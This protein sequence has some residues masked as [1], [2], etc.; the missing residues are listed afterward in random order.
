MLLFLH[1]GDTYRSMKQLR[2]IR[3][4]FLRD[5]DPSGLNLVELDAEKAS[6]EE[7]SAAVRSAPFLSTKRLVVLKGFL[8]A[9]KGKKTLDKSLLELLESVPEEAI[10]VIYEAAGSEELGKLES[11][12][13]L[14]K[15][16]FYPEYQPLS[17]KQLQDWVKQEAK[18]RGFTFS[19]DA[20]K[21]Y[22]AI[23]GDDLWKIASELDKF[24]AHA[25]AS[26]GAELDAAA[27]RDLADAKV[28]A[29]LFEFLDMV[30]AR[31]PER[32][33]AILE[34]LLEQGESEVM[35][36]SRLQ[37]HVRSLLVAADLSAHE[38]PKKDRLV[39]ELGIHPFVAA[40]VLS[41]CRYFTRDELAGLYA[42]LIDAD[43]RLK[44]GG[45][46]APRMAVDMLLLKIGGPATVA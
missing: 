17:P 29:S 28:E 45:W 20:L 18:A 39:R 3:S 36:L 16:K 37:A 6:V 34:G 15:E 40:K 11:L 26:G 23:A 21:E 42:W 32:A 4:K 35:L 27:L 1:G 30:G 43:L 22:L 2:E 31:R 41:Q 8:R 10:A 44:T 9:A 38:K 5:L 7:A 33:A 24:A 12:A 46:P 19:K 25:R 14:R 13:R